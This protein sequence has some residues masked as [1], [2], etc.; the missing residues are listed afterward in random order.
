MPKLAE[1]IEMFEQFGFQEAHIRRALALGDS[2]FNAFEGLKS[3]LQLKW[4][5]MCQEIS[6]DQQKELRPVYD[7]LMNITMKSRKLALSEDE[8]EILDKMDQIVE[9]MAECKPWA[10]VLKDMM[11]YQGPMKYG[12]QIRYFCARRGLSY[13]PPRV[14]EALLVTATK[15][16]LAGAPCPKGFA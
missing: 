12:E 15:Y 1:I 5:E 13:P 2:A 3:C 8:Q 11:E 10:L 9:G 16:R 6:A 7:R 4:G 14:E